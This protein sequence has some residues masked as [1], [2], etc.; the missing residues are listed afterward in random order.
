EDGGS[1]LAH[2]ETGGSLAMLKKAKPASLP[3]N[4]FWEKVLATLPVVMVGN[5]KAGCVQEV[6]ALMDGTELKVS[7]ADGRRRASLGTYKNYRVNGSHC[8]DMN[9][10]DE[11]TT[12]NCGHRNTPNLLIGQQSSCR[13]DFVPGADWLAAAQL[14]R[15]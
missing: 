8:F 1:W 11:R 7:G 13:L 5:T 2:G 3:P 12:R 14:V 9:T 6:T 15:T 4:R 10:G